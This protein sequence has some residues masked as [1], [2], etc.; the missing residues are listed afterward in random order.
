[1]DLGFSDAD[2]VSRGTS[3]ILAVVEFDSC[4]FTRTCKYI[5]SESY[6]DIPVLCRLSLLSCILTPS[7][8]L[9]GLVRCAF[10]LSGYRTAAQLPLQIS[11]IA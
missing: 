4:S 2:W 8:R 11:V 1:M 9:V 3:Y 7:Y 6:V 10:E 5:V